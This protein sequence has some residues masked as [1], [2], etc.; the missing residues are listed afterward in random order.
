VGE[1]GGELA[2]AGGGRDQAGIDADEAAGQGEGIDR[3]VAYDEKRERLVRL[4]T[5]G[6]KPVT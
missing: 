6:D 5:I 1:H 3:I 2:F 4:W